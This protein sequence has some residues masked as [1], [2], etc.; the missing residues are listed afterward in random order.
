[1]SSRSIGID[2][3]AGRIRAVQVARTRR[4]LTV[5]RTHVAEAA[6]PDAVA[7]VLGEL[8]TRHGFNRRARITTAMP[9]GTVCFRTVHSD[10]RERRRAR[11]VIRFHLEDDVP[12]PFDE[13]VVDLCGPASD[14]GDVLAAA[15]SRTDLDRHVRLMADAG[16]TCHAV[17]A[18]PC[19]L[20]AAMNAGA[21]SDDSPRMLVHVDGPTAV[22][23]AAQSGRLVTARAVRLPEDGAAAVLAR[24]IDL[25]WHT[26]FRR[27]MTDETCI[28]IV[29]D[30][31][32]AAQLAGEL[33]R[34]VAQADYRPEIIWQT[35]AKPDPRYAVAVGLAVRALMPAERRLN[36]L[37]AGD[38]NQPGPAGVR[39]QAMATAVL[40]SAVAAVWC[41]GLFL[42]LGRM[43]GEYQRL[44]H[45]ARRVFEQTLPGEKAVNE[46]AQLEERVA[47][48][49]KQR[50][51]LAAI[52]GTGATGVS[53]LEVIHRVSA[54]AP[55]DAGMRVSEM[56]VCGRTVRLAGTIGSFRA[57]DNLRTRLLSCGQFESVA[58]HDVATD[59]STG[60][61]R[62][63]L[64]L[65]DGGE[66]KGSPLR[67]DED[68]R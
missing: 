58:I 12:V 57:V 33:R 46:L 21:P 20:L 56:S 1:M 52:T 63:T 39:Y 49:C 43:E 4:G 53:P 13:L 38:A 36:F 62:F 14:A 9:H 54:A 27:A 11:Q 28:A 25:T 47:A 5:E 45:E 42:R 48:M 37:S 31:R 26:A 60:A 51:E 67:A 68:E 34:N 10:V 3:A 15:T 30:D 22:V 66:Q 65:M 8:A 18:A 50:D 17:D 59:R 64:A 2:I 55:D 61:V 29:G 7:Q 6:S 32:L 41:A 40:A 23:A 44:K 16:L 24:E 35:D 19:A